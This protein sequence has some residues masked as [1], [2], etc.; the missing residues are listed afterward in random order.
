VPYT[1][2][3][4]ATGN[5]GVQS[6]RGLA[7]DPRFE[8]IGGYVYDPAKYGKD[9]GELAGIASLGVTATGSIA[10][11]VELHADCVVYNALGDSGDAAQCVE[12]ICRLLESG[13]NVVSTAVSTHIHP[14]V[15]SSE[16]RERLSKA[17]VAGQATFHSTGVNPGF[18]F[19]ALPI[20]L[21][22]IARRIDLLHV[23]ELV[24]MSGYTSKSIVADL[25]G[26]GMRPEDLAPM[27]Y[28]TDVRWSPYFTCLQLFTDTFDL[29]YDDFRVRH[30]KAVTD[31]AIDLP[32]G[33]IDAGTVAVRRIVIEAMTGDH[34]VVEYELV[35]RVSDVAAPQWPSGR[36]HYA[37]T[38]DGDP[39]VTCRVDI[40]SETGRGTSIATAMLAVNAIPAVCD[41]TPGIKTRL[42]LPFVGGGYFSTGLAQAGP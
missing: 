10:D 33:R 4:W 11:I 40:D 38:I 32:W 35:W 5:V 2:A 21:S 8:V 12:D 23:V 24:D 27:E 20:A 19:D 6:L 37:V 26:M 34:T 28:M 39:T 36:A 31:V 29:R 14:D 41:A 30:D 3:Q 18:A 17:C 9:L 22:M 1:V 13:S 7:A 42:D 25:I 15:M 16:D